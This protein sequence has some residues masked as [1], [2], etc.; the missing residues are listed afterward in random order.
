MGRRQDTTA[1]TPGMFGNITNMLAYQY[2]RKEA[3]KY[4]QSFYVFI[5]FG[6]LHLEVN[7]PA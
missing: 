2:S 7:L 4:E 5:F 1:I 6:F 3:Q